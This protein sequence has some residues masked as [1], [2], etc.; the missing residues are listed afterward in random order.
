MVCTKCNG[1]GSVLNPKY[2]YE[3]YDEDRTDNWV[4]C[5]RCNGRG[6]LNPDELD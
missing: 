3:P 1:H 5:T 4:I 6:E 2:E